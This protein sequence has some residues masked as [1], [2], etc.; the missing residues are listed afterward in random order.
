MQR[1][2]VGEHLANLKKSQPLSAAGAHATAKSKHPCLLPDC[3][4]ALGVLRLRIGF[5]ALANASLRKTTVESGA[6]F[7]YQVNQ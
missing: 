3:A 2:R 6:D 4:G 5:A 1:R 7:G